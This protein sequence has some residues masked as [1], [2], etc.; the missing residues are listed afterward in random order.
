M[1]ILRIYQS[2]TLSLNGEKGKLFFNKPTST[3]KRMMELENHHLVTIILIID[4]G[5]NH[6]WM[7]KLVSKSLRGNR[8]FAVSKSLSYA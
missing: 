5:K 4:T 6:Q 3:C 7:I 8:V 2:K 1:N